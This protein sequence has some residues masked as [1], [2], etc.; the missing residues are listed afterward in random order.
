MRTNSVALSVVITFYFLATLL[1]YPV[2]RE[3]NVFQ[4]NK[5]NGIRLL[6]DSEE[7]AESSSVCSIEYEKELDSLKD[8]TNFWKI[9]RRQ[10]LNYLSVLN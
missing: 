6:D 4:V 9:R 1:L 3:S 2:L 7:L 8:A 5:L 10:K